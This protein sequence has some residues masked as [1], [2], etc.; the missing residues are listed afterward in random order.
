MIH[1]RPGA[2]NDRETYIGNLDQ[3]IED[4]DSFDKNYENT[5][6]K[7][8]PWWEKDKKLDKQD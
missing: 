1:E 4:K 7:F 3:E 6:G 5:F 2:S 8:T